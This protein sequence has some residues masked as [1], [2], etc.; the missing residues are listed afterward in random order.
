MIDAAQGVEAQ[1]VANTYLAVDAG[2]ELVPVMN[3]I[4][5]PSAEPERVAHE[6]G[7]LLGEQPEEILRISAK[8]GEGVEEVLEALV[9]HVPPPE[10]DPDA[11][12]RALIFD[13]VF[14]QYRGVIAYV[15]VVDGRFKRGEAIRA[16]QAGTR[17][18]IDDIGFRSPDM[19]KTE[20]LEA[21]EVG[22]II[23]GIKNVAKLRVGDTLTTEARPADEAAGR[24][25]R[26]TAGGFL[27]PL[28]R[29]H[30]PVRGPPRLAREA[31]AQRRLAVLR[32]RRRRR[33]SGSG[34]AAASWGCCTWT[35]CGSGWSGSTTS[36]CSRRRRTSS[37]TC[38]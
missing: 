37:T 33:R 28:S 19:V 5:L 25:P 32:A 34:S 17:A 4:D 31:L 20:T 23:T 2:L 15:R 38:G 35:S 18:D 7:E 13:S 27:R 12:P 22:Y 9:R 1:T 30:R 14:D 16:M 10:G 6:I 8:T 29:R 36:T 3:K 24:V 21:G 11:P 26:S